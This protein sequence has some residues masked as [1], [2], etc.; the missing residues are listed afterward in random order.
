M[1]GQ[2]VFFHNILVGSLVEF[3]GNRGLDRDNEPLGQIGLK[4]LPWREGKVEYHGHFAFLV[5]LAG[6]ILG[7]YT[8]EEKPELGDA[9]ERIAEPYGIGS[10]NASDWISS[11]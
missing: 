5:G 2:L 11:K 9:R 6:K 8:A 10:G 1:R 4:A 3:L 7:A